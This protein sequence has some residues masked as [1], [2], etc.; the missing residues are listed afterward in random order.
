MKEKIY[1]IK[2]IIFCNTSKVVLFY[3]NYLLVFFLLFLIFFITGIMTCSHYIS[4]VSC[5]NLINTYLCSFLKNE[6][7]YFSFFLIMSIYFVCISLIIIIFT[8]NYFFVILNS[9]ILSLMSYIYGFDLCIVIMCLGF[10][11]IILGSLILGVL[12]ISIFICIIFI[13]SIATKRL[14]ER[15]STCCSLEK[16]DYLRL[17]ITFIILGILL[18]FLMSFLFSIIHI[19]VIVD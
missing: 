1:R 13:M 6:S 11:G 15:K 9:V 12:G 7:R 5:D 18:I 2:N 8:R 19:F 14:K 3:K 16:S 10:A 17:Y 4:S